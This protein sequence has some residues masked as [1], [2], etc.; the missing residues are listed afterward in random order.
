L[1]KTFPLVPT[2]SHRTPPAAAAIR[3]AAAVLPLL[4]V[5]PV[6][7]PFIDVRKIFRDK[8]PKLAAL[9]PGFVMNRLRRIIHEDEL[10]AFLA[11]HGDKRGIAFAEAVLDRFRIRIRVQGLEHVPRRGGFILAANH[12][13]GG[14]D[15]LSLFSTLAPV[16]TDMKF[17]VNDILLRI[18]YLK[19]L[20]IG[21]NKHGRSAQK[22]LEDINRLY[23]SDQAVLLF[24]AGLVSRKRHGRI[25]DLEWKKSF[26][27]QARRHGRDVVPVH[28]SG[29]LTER[30]YRLANL[31][32]ALRIRANIEMLLLVDEL[33]RQS[34]QTIDITVRPPVPHTAFDRSRSD[35]EWAGWIRDKVY[36]G[37]P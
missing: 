8:N 12:P 17:I 18:E 31:R 33:F 4:P 14:L 20:F 32:T 1:L 3:N 24:P 30:F 35:A 9:L 27:T 19:D 36:D 26:I 10:N 29:R 5:E 13:L 37:M 28:I 15:A 11:E 34:G 2:A 16:R 25:R 7:S 22:S 6:P 23:A 21:I